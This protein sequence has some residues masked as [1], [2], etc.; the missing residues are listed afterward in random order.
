MKDSAPA[1]ARLTKIVCTLGPSSDTEEQVLALIKAGMNVARLNLSHGTR[2]DLARKID[3]LQKLNEDGYTLPI[4]MDTRGSAIR[5]GVVAVPVVI[6]EGDEVVFSSTPVTGEKRPVIE[7]NYDGFAKDVRGA[8]QIILDNGQQSFELLSVEKNGSVIAKALDGGSIGSRRHVNL[9]GADINLPSITKK[10]WDDIAYGVERGIDFIAL[11]FIRNAEEVQALR[12]FLNEKKSDVQIITKIETRRAV[13]D[14]LGDIITVSDGIMVARGDLGTEIPI[15]ELPAFQD[16]IVARCRDAGKPVIVATQMLESMITNPLPTR[17]EATDV[18][19]AA[20]TRA[21]ATM[22]SGETANGRYPVKCVETMDRILR[23]TEAR[24]ARL[25][26]RYDGA[27]HND[28]EARAEAAV[29]LAQSTNADVI[30]AF[31][32]TGRT[33]RDV[34]RFRPTIPVI[35]CTPEKRTKRK[36][37]LLYGV[38]PLIVPFTTPEGT[39]NAGMQAAKEAGLADHGMHAVLLS[40]TQAKDA[41]VSTVQMRDIP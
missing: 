5:T 23:R 17:A 12:K 39:V 22:L 2:E 34:T 9:P 29:S 3:L 7:V 14:N 31:T 19:H 33:A 36:L 15:E 38:F 8:E 1:R 21:D 41:P 37:G 10:D 4:L 28:R 24:E 30:F 25:K 35:A 27:V 11:S 32:R 18:S 16:E 20:M 26:R 13:A 40:D 6:K